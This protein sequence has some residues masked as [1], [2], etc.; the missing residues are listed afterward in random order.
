MYNLFLDDIRFPLDIYPNEEWVIVRDFDQFKSYIEENGLPDMVSFD[1]DLGLNIPEGYDAL[2]WMIAND[3]IITN[4]RVHSDNTVAAKQIEGLANNWLKHLK[5]EGIIDDYNV[6]QQFAMFLRKNPKI[7][8]YL[9]HWK[10]FLEI[11]NQD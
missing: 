10:T 7:S 9:E 11:K 3:I 1:N 8:L 2:K 6:S 5:S 4:I